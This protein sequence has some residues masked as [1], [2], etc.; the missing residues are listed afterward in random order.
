MIEQCL[1]LICEVSRAKV[2]YGKSK[3]YFSSETSNSIIGSI[4]ELSGILIDSDFGL[5]MG[6]PDFDLDIKE[7]V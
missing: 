3:I 7:D 1:N 5:Y 6:I 2:N 4:T